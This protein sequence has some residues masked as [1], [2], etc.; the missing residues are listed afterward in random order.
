MASQPEEPE[1]ETRELAL[2]EDCLAE[3]CAFD[4]FIGLQYTLLFARI[5]ISTAGCYLQAQATVDSEDLPGNELRCDREK[6]NGR[7]DLLRASIAL[8][9]SLLRHPTHESRR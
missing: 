5:A 3:E 2:E 9:G 6:Q 7:A 1:F 8:H 4:F